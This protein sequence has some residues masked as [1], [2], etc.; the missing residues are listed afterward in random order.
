VIGWSSRQ[1]ILGRWRADDFPK[2]IRERARKVL[3][4][5]CAVRQDYL[6]DTVFH[7]ERLT[8]KQRRAL[9]DDIVSLY[10]ACLLDL[11]KAGQ[12]YSIVYPKDR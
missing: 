3:T 5:R 9:I 10:E 7:F 12:Y 6:H 2:H 1:L 8:P 11:G 4:V